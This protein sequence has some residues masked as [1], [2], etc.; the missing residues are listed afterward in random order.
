M[1]QFVHLIIVGHVLILFILMQISYCG[2]IVS[3]SKK[4]MNHKFGEK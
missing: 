2:R 3:I 4:N 1:D